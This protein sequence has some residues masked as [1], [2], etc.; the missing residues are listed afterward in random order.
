MYIYEKFCVNS[1]GLSPF[2]VRTVWYHIKRKGSNSDLDKTLPTCFKRLKNQKV[3]V[4]YIICRFHKIKQCSNYMHAKFQFV[5]F[6]QRLG[7]FLPL[8][9][10]KFRLVWK[11]SDLSMK[12]YLKYMYMYILPT[13]SYFNKVFCIRGMWV[14]Y[15]SINKLLTLHAIIEI[16]QTKDPKCV[17]FQISLR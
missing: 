4:I 16:A 15:F 10:T 17:L 6:T 3:C 14:V 9:A 5:I 13:F 8:T 12:T 11:S 1:Q 2:W 7:D